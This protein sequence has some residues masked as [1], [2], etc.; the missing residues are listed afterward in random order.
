VLIDE[1]FQL[2]GVVEG[3]LACILWKLAEKVYRTYKKILL[4]FGIFHDEHGLQWEV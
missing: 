3:L 2:T 4:T 1:D